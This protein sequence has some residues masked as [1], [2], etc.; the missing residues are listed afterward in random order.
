MF[1]SE[2][3]KYLGHII[4]NNTVRPIKDNLVSIYNFPTPKTQKNIRQ[5]LGKINFYH[6]YIPKISTILELLH[7][8]L[9]K[10]IKF[11]WSENCE[12]SFTEIKKLLCSQ[13][14]LEIFDKNLPIKIFTDASI[15]G[16]GAILK[17]VQQNGEEK[18]VA[19]F[20][21]KLNETQKKKKA[22]YLE[23]LA[24]K[25]AVKYWEY[26]LI[27]RKFEVYSDH[28][29][30]ENLNIKARTDEELGDLTYYLSQFDFNIKYIPG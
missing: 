11:N 21:R 27:G 3:I 10:D 13:P 14:V 28:K 25:E 18:P 1:A 29:P 23:C 15:E 16:M 19:Y 6:E 9:R 7:R 4:E 20:S 8:L 17:Q 30:L 22:I 2:S 24:I 5:F 26:W 12:K